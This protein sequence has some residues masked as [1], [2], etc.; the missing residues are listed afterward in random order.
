M[1]ADELRALATRAIA[2]NGAPHK[3]AETVADVLVEADLR[4]VASHGVARLP[5]YV[6][7]A[8]AGLID[9]AAPAGK[10]RQAALRTMTLPAE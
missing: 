9:P 5:N 4:G 2:A 7:R 3:I 10:L 6:A 8:K 1:T